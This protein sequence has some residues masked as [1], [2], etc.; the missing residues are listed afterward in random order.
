[1]KRSWIALIA[2]VAVCVFGVAAYYGWSLKRSASVVPASVQSMPASQGET[3]DETNLS[4]PDKTDDA[5][6][7][8]DA[9]AIANLMAEIEA[10]ATGDE[11]ALEAEYAGESESFMDGAVVMEQLGTSYDE[12]SY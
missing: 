12:A 8:S 7:G 9:E 4:S 3:A 1:M 10:T 2:V 11:G 5:D 6:L